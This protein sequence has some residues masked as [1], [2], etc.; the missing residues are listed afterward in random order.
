MKNIIFQID[1]GI[2]KSI[3][4]TA[5]CEAIKKQYPKD[6]LIVISA[7][8]QVFLCNPHVD[9]C[10]V[11]GNLAY[12]YQDYIEGKEVIAFLHNPYFETSYIE[13]N[14][15]LIETWCEMFKIEYNGEEPQ[16]YLTQRE[17]DYYSNQFNSDKPIMVIQTNGGAQEQQIKYSWSR[18]IPMSTAQKVVDAFTNEY[19]VVHIRREDQIALNNTTPV[20]GDF[21]ALLVLIKLSKARLFIDS[22]AQ[23]VAK[24]LNL[25]SV[26]CWIANTPKQFGYSNN[27]NILAE[28]ET[29][30]P[31]LKNSVFQKYNIVGDFI[32]FPYEN[33]NQIFDADKIIESIKELFGHGE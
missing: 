9:K 12:F 26:V 19:N 20:T 10:L 33:E 31:E 14:K 4:A 13:R 8:P 11:H 15:H 7:Y 1:G 22:F 29:A 6:K 25:D 32:E 28:K 17:I 18:D 3:M 16:L 2:G 5:V 23:H 24:A 27:I 30:S 21:R